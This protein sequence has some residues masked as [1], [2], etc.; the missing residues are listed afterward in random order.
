M[1]PTSIQTAWL[2][3]TAHTTANKEHIS[4]M[5]ALLIDQLYESLKRDIEAN[6]QAF[7]ASLTLVKEKEEQDR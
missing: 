1:F 3:F 2:A 7:K 4:D 5:T 6:P